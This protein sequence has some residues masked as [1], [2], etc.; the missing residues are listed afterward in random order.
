MRQIQL[1]TLGAAVLVLTSTI[2]CRKQRSSETG[3]VSDSTR[4]PVAAPVAETPDT[5]P[6][7]PSFS[8]DQRQAF[9]QSIRQQLTGIDRQIA[10]LRSQAKSR[11]GAVSDRALATI[12]ASR[13]AVERDL[14]RVSSATAA[15]WEQVKTGVNQGVEKLNETIEAAQPK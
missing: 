2:G 6:A 15:N 14:K 12:V 5:T 1:F 8:F 3:G 7:V 11:G 10:E 4:S 13:R 9:T